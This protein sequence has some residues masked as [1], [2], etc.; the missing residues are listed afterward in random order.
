MGSDLKGKFAS[1][2]DRRWARLASFF[3]GVLT[4][5]YSLY[6]GINLGK[7][8]KFY[9]ALF[10]R[11]TRGSTIEIGNNCEFRSARWSNEVG[12]NRGCMLSTL[13]EG[14]Q[15]KIGSNCGF[16]GTVIGAAASVQIGDNVMCGGN[17]TITDTDWH[18]IEPDKRKMPGNC[19]PVIIEDNV[20]LGLN[21]IVL[22]GVTI[23][24]NSVIGAGSV[25]SKSIPS[26]VIAAGQPAKVVKKFFELPETV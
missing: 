21:A 6:R 4:R 2:I 25:V 22:K 17:V 7:H 10:F 26:N 1:G 8:C 9:G 24:K 23:G 11:R 12:L 19:A 14:A 3:S 20:W 16:S 13:R 18:G 15:I 5:L